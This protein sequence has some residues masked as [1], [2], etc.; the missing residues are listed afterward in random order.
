MVTNALWGELEGWLAASR[1]NAFDDLAPPASED[2]VR[3]FAAHFSRSPPDE[4][5]ASLARHDG[6]EFGSEFLFGKMRWL[7]PIDVALEQAE[8]CKASARRRGT[9]EQPADIES[10]GP[11]L[12]YDWSGSWIPFFLDNDVLYCIDMAPAP[13]GTPGQVV[14]VDHE[15]LSLTRVASSYTEFLGKAFAAVRT[16]APWPFRGRHPSAP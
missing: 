9:F 8:A 6:E 14:I 11:V 2:E 4:L 12:P 1:P 16:D 13:G 15:D 10:F 3:R 5:L 7:L